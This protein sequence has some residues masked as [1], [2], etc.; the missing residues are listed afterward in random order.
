MNQVLLI[1]RLTKDPE[2]RWDNNDFAVA[3]F[4]LAVNR[5]AKKDGQEADFIRIVYFGKQAETVQ[6]Y[7]FKGQMVGVSGRIQTG[8][9]TNKDGQKV[10]TTDVVGDRLDILEWKE[11]RETAG[12]DWQ[13]DQFKF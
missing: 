5:P 1:G 7:C 13:E 12:T 6:R 4:T 3:K 2:V 11:K 9:Y 8:S 10:Y